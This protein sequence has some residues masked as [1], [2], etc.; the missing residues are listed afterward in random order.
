MIAFMLL[1]LAC[2]AVFADAASAGRL[3]A[4]LEGMRSIE[5]D[6]VQR[7]YDEDGTL[8]QQSEGHVLLAHPGRF[9]WQTRAPFEQLVV[10]DG[11]TVWQYDPDLAQV[12]IRPMD[13]RADQLPS[14]LLSG[15]IAAVEA[16]FE[17]DSVPAQ[18]A[19]EHFELRAHEPGGLFSRLDVGF[20]GGVLRSLSIGDGLGQ[21]TE[22]IFSAVTPLVA[23]VPDAFT[24]VT[25]PG[26]DELHDE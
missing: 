3:A 22:M 8:V 5:A 26:V 14:L 13:Q 9:R 2:P 18:D 11:H 19:G 1:V 6:F 24:F 16:Q 23:A 12:V 10:S 21:R 7:L 4:L 15:D 17:I 20:S 25:P